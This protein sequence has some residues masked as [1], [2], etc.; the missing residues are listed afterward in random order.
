MS[1]L[2][3]SQSTLSPNFAP[4]VY[5]MLSRGQGLAN[6]PYQEFTGQRFAGPSALQQQAFQGLGSLQTPSQFGT[7]TNFLTQAGQA[8]GNLAY[9]PSTFGNFYQAPQQFQNAQFGNQFTGTSAYSP[10]SF[11]SQYNAPQAGQAT[12]FTN[13]FARPVSYQ[14]T[15]ATSGFQAP[16]AFTPTNYTAGFQYGPSAATQFQ[17][18]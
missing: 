3:P 12:Q 11:Q 13:Q 17:N 15:T 4:Y 10:T 8:A 14:P 18:Q 1:D 9:G 5:D 16:S 6:L 2:D 7:A